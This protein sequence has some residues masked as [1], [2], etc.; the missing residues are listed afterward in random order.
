M[1]WV[2][3]VKSHFSGLRKTDEV[4]ELSHLTGRLN[5]QAAKEGVITCHEFV[6]EDGSLD[7]ATPKAYHDMRV[8]HE[9]CDR[10]IRRNWSLPRALIVGHPHTQ[11]E[12]VRQWTTDHVMALLIRLGDARGSQRR[13][14]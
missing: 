6:A 5:T 11:W 8:Q 10:V 9:V 1:H 7:G 4:T 12:R 14:A 3:P 13:V 2:G